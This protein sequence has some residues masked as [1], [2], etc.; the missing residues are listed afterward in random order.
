MCIRVGRYAFQL[1]RRLRNFYQKFP[2]LTETNP[3]KRDFLLWLTAAYR[4]ELVRTLNL[5]GIAVPVFM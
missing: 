4:A 5:L 1:A 3:T 2:V